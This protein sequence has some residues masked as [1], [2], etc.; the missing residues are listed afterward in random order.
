MF[1]VKILHVNLKRHTA[2]AGLG[3]IALMIL[4]MTAISP[5]SFASLLRST[6]IDIGVEHTQ[7]LSLSMQVGISDTAGYIEFFSE[8]SE[9]ILISVPSTWVRREVKNAEL[10]DVSAEAPSL[11]FTRWS[12]PARSGISFQVRESPDSLLL[13]NPTGVQMKLNLA[14]VDVTNDTVQKEVVLIQGDTVKLW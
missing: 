2:P 5:P 12:L 7:P 13:H 3:L 11:G 6:S 8:S 14:F 10:H 9:T 4:S 1:T